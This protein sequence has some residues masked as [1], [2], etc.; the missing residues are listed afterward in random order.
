MLIVLFLCVIFVVFNKLWHFVYQG[1]DYNFANFLRP[2]NIAYLFTGYTGLRLFQPLFLH[3]IFSNII[4]FFHYSMFLY[5][6]IERLLTYHVI[7]P[8]KVYNSMVFFLLHSQLCATMTTVNFRTFST[9][10]KET[11]TV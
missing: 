2:V 10:Q 5:S 8:L 9:P 6:L 7:Y 3:G 11:R 1:A 4:L